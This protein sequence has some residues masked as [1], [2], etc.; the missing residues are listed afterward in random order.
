QMRFTKVNDEFLFRVPLDQFC[1]L[2]RDTLIAAADAS[3]VVTRMTINPVDRNLKFSRRNEDRFVSRPIA[4]P[5]VVIPDAIEKV[6][7][8]NPPGEPG[9]QHLLMASEHRFD[10]ESHILAR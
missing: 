1:D 4:S 10:G 2:S 8:G 9:L 5:L 3:H 7:F 6:L